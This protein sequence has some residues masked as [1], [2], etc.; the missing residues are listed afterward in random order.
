MIGA[1]K[2]IE[3]LPKENSMSITIETLYPSAGSRKLKTLR[4]V[5]IRCFT[6]IWTGTSC[7]SCPS[8]TSTL[9]VLCDTTACWCRRRRGSRRTSRRR[10][11]R[12]CVASTGAEF[13][14][15]KGQSSLAILSPITLMRVRIIARTAVRICRI[16]IALNF[17][18]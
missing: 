11:C 1:T 9:T 14:L 6:C 17:A 4:I 5:R 18:G 16:A 2:F 7:S 15:D 10:S 3:Q 8:L 13:G 12:V